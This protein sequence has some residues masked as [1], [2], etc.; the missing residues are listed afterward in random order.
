MPADTRLPADVNA[1][2][3]VDILDL[4]AVAGGIDT[5]GGNQLSVEEIELTVLIAAEQAAE[6][7]AAAGAPMQIHS[8]GTAALLSTRI[9]AKNVADALDVLRKDVQLRKEIPAVLETFLAVLSEITV[10]PDTTALLPNYP[11]PF[12]PETWI[13]YHLSKDTTVILTIHDVRGSVV[14][15]LVL[16]HQ[17][18]GVYR[19]K[20]R[21]AYW[22]GRNAEGESV[23]S[24]LYFYTLTADDFNATRKMLIRK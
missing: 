15:V 14:R 3:V 12:N 11:N 24:G 4:T 13:P 1:D 9:T 6:L 8:S 5:T 7:E 18:A 17:A 21:A 16:G 20:H 2:S 10:T 22:D 23:A 19:S